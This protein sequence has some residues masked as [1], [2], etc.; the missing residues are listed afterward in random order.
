MSGAPSLVG[1]D[2]DWWHKTHIL[3][4]LSPDKPITPT[5]AAARERAKVL[6]GKRMTP[7]QA[8]RLLKQL[9]KEGKVVKTQR[10][11]ALI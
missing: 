10:G 3:N 7:W 9:E 8:E 6:R 2:W 1:A 4:V 11:Y 5:T